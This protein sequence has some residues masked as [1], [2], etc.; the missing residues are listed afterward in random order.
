MEIIWNLELIMIN[1]RNYLSFSF[2]LLHYN[3]FKIFIHTTFK[4]SF[5]LLL[6]TMLKKKT[7]RVKPQTSLSYDLEMKPTLKVKM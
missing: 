5:M 2:I 1:V 6:K 7:V 4:L 3:H